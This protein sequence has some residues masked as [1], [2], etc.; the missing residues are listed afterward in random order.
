MHSAREGDTCTH[1]RAMWAG[2]AYGG[3]GRQGRQRG[4][5]TACNT[6]AAANGIGHDACPAC[7]D[8]GGDASGAD[9][10]WARRYTA[11]T[12]ALRAMA[13]AV[14]GGM[15]GPLEAC[16]TRNACARALP[17]IWQ[18]RG[19]VQQRRT[20]AYDPSSALYTAD[21]STHHARGNQPWM[22]VASMDTTITAR[23]VFLVAF[24]DLGR[25]R[26]C[27]EPKGQSLFFLVENGYPEMLPTLGAEELRD[28]LED[29][30]L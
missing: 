20:R 23:S 10:T 24:A 25:D 17:R 22:M 28:M 16:A 26:T 8:R 6:S 30:M 1:A 4:G 13:E 9:R 2:T 3:R 15:H 19:A 18:G 27:K 11:S 12:H 29:T 21:V 7:P 14:P 5:A